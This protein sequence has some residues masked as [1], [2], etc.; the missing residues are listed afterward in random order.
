VC[1]PV[2]PI[3]KQ[4]YRGVLYGVDMDD[5]MRVLPDLAT[6][7]T[8]TDGPTGAV[9]DA[10]AV[11][12]DAG[13]AHYRRAGVFPFVLAMTEPAAT[14]RKS[15]ERIV[16]LHGH[17]HPSFYRRASVDLMQLV[18][19]TLTGAELMAQVSQADRKAAWRLTRQVLRWLF[20]HADHHLAA[21]HRAVVLARARTVL[22]AQ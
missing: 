13:G 6:A 21:S 4:L 20:A 16:G 9:L 18:A 14:G 2:R 22:V 11:L 3:D 10:A 8:F 1:G 19:K 12:S 5:W 15:F 7:P 17:G